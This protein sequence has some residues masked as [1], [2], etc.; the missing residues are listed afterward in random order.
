MIKKQLRLFLVLYGLY[1]GE[2]IGQSTAY[3]DSLYRVL[4]TAI[5]DSN[6]VISY[7]K[8]GE[9]FET[10]DPD[11]ALYYYQKSWELGKALNYKRGMGMNISYQIVILNNRGKFREAL[12]LCEQAVEMYKELKSE[13]DIAIAYNNLG[14]EYQYL[15]ELRL[16]VKNY[17]LAT[18]I[19][20]KLKDSTLVQL[21]MNNVSS[22]FSTLKEYDRGHQYASASYNIAVQL[23]DTFGM[24]SSLVNLAS[25]EIAQGLYKEAMAHFTQVI[26]F[27]EYLDDY[28]LALDGYTNIGTIYNKLKQYPKAME[29]FRLA[30][31]LARRHK[32]PGYELVTWQGFVDTYLALG[33][34]KN[35]DMAVS[36]AIAL[37]IET[38]SRNEL[39]DLY[40][41]AAIVKEKSGDLASALDYRKR[42]ELLNDTLLNEKIR[43]NINELE[44]Q[45][46]T[47]KKDQSIA[48]QKLVLE[49]NKV[50]I[51][52]KNVLL[53]WTLSGL[54]ILLLLT[55][56]SYWFYRQR[57]RLNM[58][59]ILALQKEQE[60]VRLKAMLEGQDAERQRISKEMHD[61][62]GSGLTSI[63]YMSENLMSREPAEI[64]GIA[65]KI[66]R[67]AN[68]L[69][70]KMNEIIWSLNKEYNTIE[71]L[72][73]YIR[74]SI[75]ELLE[76]RDMDYAF[77]VPDEIPQVAISGEQRRNIYLVVKES[78]HNAIKHSSASLITITFDF[79]DQ[80]S[81][82]IH[83]NGK[84][85]AMDKIRQFGNG[86]KN[87]KQRMETI[88]GRFCI[89]PENG[90]TVHVSLP[91]QV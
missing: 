88:G 51:E 62:V 9:L 55:L 91:P 82:T 66:S 52:H 39:N 90:T 14:N 79:T 32:N 17:L 27:G 20:E 73:V 84:G 48:E 8:Y 38:G 61:D 43:N 87:M 64:G 50:S 11:S 42:F 86:L 76:Y 81:I 49:R 19:V 41:K 60:V 46:Q 23:R 45:Y 26:N 53:A 5:E 63:L 6:K 13:R 18:D 70:E 59:T 37:A 65:P 44:V 16:A 78:V 31:E 72:V 1:A 22:I 40:L 67:T 89:T 68:S 83:D 77:E 24:A 29:Q 56:A 80:F 30:L 7:L 57:Q 34:M 4:Q 85:I 47:A 33:Q 3:K 15:G 2:A 69:V 74:H 12:A 36:R 58:Q 21:F 75:S 25:N 10:S 35:A 54:A 71:D 28:T